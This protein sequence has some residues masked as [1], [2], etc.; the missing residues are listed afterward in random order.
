MVERETKLKEEKAAVR[1]EKKASVSGHFNRMP[2]VARKNKTKE[3]HSG[4][5]SGCIEAGV[6][7]RGKGRIGSNRWTSLRLSMIGPLREAAKKGESGW[8]EGR[9]AWEGAHGERAYATTSWVRAMRPEP[10]NGG[11]GHPGRTVG[12]RS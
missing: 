5:R 11:D 8:G 6:G 2:I 1:W 4:E 7:K 9:K 12:K 10:R 3:S